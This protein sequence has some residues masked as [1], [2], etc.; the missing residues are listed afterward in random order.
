MPSISKAE[1]A[2]R[3]QNLLNRLDKGSVAIIATNPE[4]IR[5]GDGHYPYR[6]SSQFYYLTGFAEP[7]AVLVLIPGRKEGE[8]I[9]F[10]RVRDPAQEQWTGYRAG[11][12]GACA[13][14]G[15]DEA[16]PY[17]E[18]DARLPDLLQGKQTLFYSIGKNAAWDQRMMTALNSLRKRV[19][20]GITA[21]EKLQNIDELINEMRL[22]KSPA[23]IEMMRYVCEASAQAHIAAMQ[24]C[25]P[26]RYEYQL[27]ATLR[28]EF[29]VRGCRFEGYPSI[30]GSG[31]N[32]CVLHYIENNAELKKGDLV[33]ID[34]G[35]EYQYYGADI[36]RV[37]PV[38][39]KFS[40]EQTAIYNLV[41]KA[42]LACIE[43]IKP[44]LNW[45]VLQETVVR[46]L[47]S[48]L[49]ELEILQGDLEDLINKKA[50]SPFYMHLSGHWLGMDTHDVGSY[51][52][53]D[54][55]VRNL[56]AGMIL[57]VEPGLYISATIPDVD[58]KWHNIGVRIEDDVL[59]TTQG[60]EVLTRSAPKTV[61]EIEALMAH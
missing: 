55:A 47:T 4:T 16:F 12:E 17:A 51:R 23:E 39:G 18:L 14:F 2:Q 21:P 49:L 60:Y 43:K 54:G 10:N 58:P 56:E 33:L 48:G 28:Y 1:Y 22:I 50:Y 45:A 24:A 34:A 40:V 5:N 31:E 32:A 42:Q 7:E 8:F 35:A 30:V 6:P 44:G 57:T 11:Q 36:T 41:L 37:F 38:N 13:T 59:V 53:Q 15:A 19:R 20:Q 3:R 52:T 29:G 27:E 46:V 26:G 9:L 25:K 61:P